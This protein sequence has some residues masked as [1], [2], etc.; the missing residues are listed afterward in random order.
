[1]LHILLH[2]IIEKETQLSIFLTTFLPVGFNCIKLQWKAIV[3]NVSSV[4]VAH[5]MSLK[6]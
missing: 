4:V 2:I 3:Y 1:M 6:I 5:N